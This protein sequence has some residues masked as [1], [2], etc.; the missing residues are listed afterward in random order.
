NDLDQQTTPACILC[1]VYPTTVQGYF[2]HLKIYHRKATLIQNERYILC[3]CGLRV[4]SARFDPDH[5]KN[6]DGRQF[7]I[8]W[9]I[10]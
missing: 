3:S 10:K 9:N 8:H 1:E 2:A 7:S 4:T 5:S 6:C